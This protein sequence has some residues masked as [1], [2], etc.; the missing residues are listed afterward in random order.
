MKRL[1]RKGF[2]LGALLAVVGP[3]LLAGL[4][5]DDP[6][7]IT[8]YSV[9]GADHGYRLLWV[10]LLSTIA[11]VLFHGLAA[12][13][14]V[15]TGQGLI[16]LVRQR[17]GVRLG[18]AALAVLVVAN[19][20]TTCAEFAGIAAGAELFGISRY[21]S[22]PAAA[23]IVSLLVLRG[24]FH[25]VERFLLLLSTVF[26]AYIA[27]GVLANPDWGAAFHGMLVPSLPANSAGIAIVT[28]T[29]GTTLAPWGLSFIQSYAVDKKL[30]TEDLSLERVDVIT[31]AVLTGIIGF[32]VVVACAATLHRDGRSIHDAADAA[33]ALQ[34]LAG[35]AASTLFAVGLIG[36]A[37]LAASILPLSTA[38]SVC[39]YAGIEAA[40]DDPY[41]EARPF[42]LTFGIVTLVGAL[43]VLIPNIPLVTILV[44]T[45]V[46]NAVLLVPLLFAM[47]GIGRD[48]DLMGRFTIG[49]ASTIAYFITTAVVVL[50]VAA[51][52]VTSLTR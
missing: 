41:T 26:L 45:Q 5:D 30:R 3:G 38:Y 44:A 9:L 11:L 42:Y 13:M 33:V 23:V 19:V 51:L 25:R 22:V 43:T 32:F 2:S 20:G 28:A 27:S 36:A 1:G 24:S 16:G 40:V 17:Y 12:R 29:V 47:I 8:T 14:G 18:G 15:V 39:E 46:L 34:P 4:S 7:G 6:A 52:A 48:R 10:L 21:A 49:R 37:F 50:C 35:T 31:G